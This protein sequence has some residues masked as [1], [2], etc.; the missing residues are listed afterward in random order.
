MRGATGARAGQVKN[1]VVAGG[2]PMRWIFAALAVLLACAGPASA[3]RTPTYQ[4]GAIHPNDLGKFQANGGLTGVGGVLGDANGR[5]VNPFSI[6]DVQDKGLCLN[7]AVTG[8]RYNALC[9]GHDAN[10]NALI[11]LDSYGGL[12]PT[13]LNC[14][15]NGVL[16]TNCLSGGSV[17]SLSIRPGT[18]LG[19]LPD[20]ITS[21][22]ELFL[23]DTAITAGVYTYPSTVTVDQQ[24]RLTSIASGSAPALPCTSPSGSLQYDASGNFGCATVNAG[25]L[26]TGGA[27]S[28]TQAF[29]TQ[30]SGDYTVLTGDAAKTIKAG[31]HTYTL[32]QAGTTGFETGWGA[33]ILNIGS[34]DAT[35]STSTS[36]FQGAGGGTSLT[37]PQNTWACPS[38]D[39][40]NYQTVRGGGTGSGSGDGTVTS[41]AATAPS[42]VLSIAGSPITTTGTLVFNWAG[43]SGGVPY[44]SSSSAIASSAA[45]SQDRI[46]L[47][48][49]SGGA[50]SVA[51]SLGTTTTLL[52]GNAAGPPTFGAVAL[53]A[54]VSGNLSVSH[55]NSGTSASSSTFWRGDGTWS[56]PAGTATNGSNNDI[57]TSDGSGAFGTA[58]TPASGI[59]TFL[60]TP[61]SANLRAALTDEVGAGAAYFVGGALGTPASGTA[62]N[63][64]GLPLSTGVTGDLAVTHLDGGASA[65]ASTF[66]RGDGA[67]ATPAGTS[68]AGSSGDIQTNSSGSFGSFTPGSG[69]VTFLTT[70]SSA[71][72]RAALTDETGTGITYFVGGALGTPSSAT[73]SNGTGLPLTTGVTGNLP[74]T[75]LNSGTSASSSTF[76][77]GDGTWG[78]PAGAAPAGSTNDLQTN[79][80]GGSF[81]AITPASGIAT[82]LATPSSA[83]LRAALTDETGT[84]IAYFVGGALGTPSSGVATNLTSIPVANATGVLP[85][86]NG[87]AGTISG[88]LKANGSGTVSAAAC[89]DLSDDGT[90]CTAAT[91]TSG[92]TLPFLNGTNTWS[93]TQT[94]GSVVG[95]VDT[96]T[97]TTYTLAASDCGETIRA[98]NAS[99]ITITT[100]NSLPVGCSIAI[101]QVGAGQ[102]T[103]ANG[104][105]A[106]LVSRNSYTK[107]SGQWAVIGLYVESNSGGSAAQF[108]LTGDGA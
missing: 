47:G 14:R 37:I 91:G 89:A 34:G 78:T 65:S 87:G 13:I 61:S 19:S 5:G 101:L 69:V 30:T 17:T 3:Q 64:T 70:P 12:N 71:N 54:D 95:S 33:C 85:A 31:A 43:T 96:Q 24:G 40:T 51:G 66:W 79:A 81:G 4:G 23:E 7:S 83:N 32:P 36:T 97:G 56:T 72:L 39:G 18:G 105:G 50:P 76:W 92:A 84:G 1:S 42:G 52:H 46:V 74:V 38:S 88:V 82:F 77:R 28:M 90:A 106:T 16:V 104:S 15:I 20:P 59:A 100:L 49:G 108:V 67:W 99:A 103:I 27:L 35:L 9:L 86:A 93:G 11:T 8:G 48:G 75:N 53:A 26:M 62:S 73:L 60:A 22:G 25:L 45:L 6:L 68:P 63:L 107:T 41:A 55:L 80:G 58:I 102:I 2:L 57:L 94:F 44:F 10:N 98:S 29:N 21:V